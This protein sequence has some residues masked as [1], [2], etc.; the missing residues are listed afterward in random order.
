LF[1]FASFVSFKFVKIQ[2]QRTTNG[3]QLPFHEKVIIATF[4]GG[5]GG[6][7]GEQVTVNLCRKSG[8]S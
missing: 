6:V 7:V 3:R 2:G 4:A 1:G 8:G 5:I